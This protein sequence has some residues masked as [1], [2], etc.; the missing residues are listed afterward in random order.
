MGLFR[1]LLWGVVLAAI[2][3]V[4]VLIANHFQVADRLLAFFLTLH[5]NLPSWASFE[6][7]LAAVVVGCVLVM[8]LV[9][10]AMFA[11]VAVMRQQMHR[12]RSERAAQEVA[13][14]RALDRLKAQVRQEYDRLIGLSATLTQRLDKRA[15]L[16]NIL[17]AASQITNLPQADSAVGIWVLDFTTDRLQFEMG[18]R[19]DETFFTK[20]QFDLSEQPFKRFLARREV[21]LLPKW[22][23]EMKFL[24]PEKLSQLGQASAV[25]L[26]PLIIER[27]LLGCLVVFCHP[28]LLLAYRDQQAFFNAA[29]G[30]LT[31]ALAIAIQGELAILDRLTGMVNQTYFL[32]RLAQEI[33]RSTRY[34]LTLGLLMIDIDNFKAVNDT[35]GHPQGDAVLRIVSKLIKN[36]VRAIDLVGRYGGEEFVV[37]LPETGFTEERGGSSGVMV[38]AERIRKAI[39]TEFRELQKPLAITISIGVAVRRFPQDRSMDARDLIRVADE[40]LYKAKTTGKNRTSVQL[41]EEHQPVA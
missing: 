18:I 23:G 9:L 34:Q 2:L 12:V 19:C 33:E 37:M 8:L 20:T 27:T 25:M 35:L 10:I 30:Q 14:Q 5:P 1:A 29:W 31:L 36:E 24:V 38:V 28:D 6:Q 26:V 7:F 13:V 3:T 17:Q 22:D 32:K 21:L 4:A 39:E 16:Q 11:S 41:P 40:Q 15:L